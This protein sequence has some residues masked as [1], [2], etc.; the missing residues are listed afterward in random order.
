MIESLLSKAAWK[1]HKA[2]AD[3]ARE[4]GACVLC[5]AEYGCQATDQVGMDVD[6]DR[7]PIEFHQG[8]AERISRIPKEAFPT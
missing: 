5:A 7:K 2:A 8:C 6:L 1:V 3:A 4:A